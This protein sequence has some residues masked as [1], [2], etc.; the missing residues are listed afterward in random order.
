M[1]VVVRRWNAADEVLEQVADE[2]EVR[3]PL[4]LPVR[5]GGGVAPQLAGPPS[6]VWLLG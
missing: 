5:A 2:D 6:F 3:L 4:S 1:Q